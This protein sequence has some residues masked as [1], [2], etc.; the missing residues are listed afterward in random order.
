[1]WWFWRGQLE[2]MD[3]LKLF[4]LLG[5]GNTGLMCRGVNIYV[6]Y[7]TINRLVVAGDFSFPLKISQ[8]LSSQKSVAMS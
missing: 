5:S 6:F 2:R 8:I 4:S 7:S 3:K 1:M